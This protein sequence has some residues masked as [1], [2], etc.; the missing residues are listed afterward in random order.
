VI[1]AIVGALV[2]M[3]AMRALAYNGNNA[4][5]YADIYW[6]Q[7]NTSWP[8]YPNDCANFVSQALYAG[9]DNMTAN[10]GSVTDDRYW[11]EQYFSWPYPG[12]GAQQQLD[13][14][15]RPV[16]VSVQQRTSCPGRFLSGV[17]LHYCS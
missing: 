15:R 2:S 8:Q 13:G 11:F 10:V 7:Y 17:V 3:P 4:G 6:S 14:G 1:L 16:A 5:I 12:W 9:G